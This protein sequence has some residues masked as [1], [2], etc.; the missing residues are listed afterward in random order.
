MLTVFSIPKPFHGHIGVIQRN[1]ITSWSLL[2]PKPEI[3]LFGDEAGA[4]EISQELGLRH[5]P[6]VRRNA[7]GTPLVND[8]F[9]KAQSLAG[10][11]ILCYVN[12]DIVLLG[13]FMKAVQQVA[14]QC[15][16]F[17]MSGQRT[18]VDLQGL[19]EFASSDWE[20]RMCAL[21]SKEGLLEVP[22][23]IDYFVF[24][25]GL[26]SDIPPFAL[27]R[28]Y[29]DDWLFWK[30]CSLKVPV[31]DASSAV[32]AIHQNHDY[33]HYATGWEGM[34]KGEEA[35]ANQKLAGVGGTYSLEDATQSL[36][37]QGIRWNFGHLLAPA[38]RHLGHCF[39]YLWHLLMVWTA[40]I[41]HPLRLR[42]RSIAG[43][44]ARIG[45]TKG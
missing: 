9:A 7:H 14:E 43:L 20:L 25:R 2:R 12:A 4:A 11:D 23:G 3:I 26:Y 21:A 10:H 34:W 6:D 45:L 17:L 31:V 13:D 8:I 1:A 19:I 22:N 29:W 40:P 44:M 39:G 30:A 18:N 15:G 42:R 27:G 24:R 36:T 33:A 32:L 35:L 41:R 28:F 5:V 37:A 38:K 16:Q